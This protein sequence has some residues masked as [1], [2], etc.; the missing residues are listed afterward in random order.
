MKRLLVK[1]GAKGLFFALCFMPLFTW[2]V[3][4]TS[5]FYNS[6]ELPEEYPKVPLADYY[7][8]FTIKNWP[9]NSIDIFEK[10]LADDQERKKNTVIC[11][12]NTSEARAVIYS[13]GFFPGEPVN[14]S[15]KT[16]DGD[17]KESIKFIPNPIFARS[18]RDGAKV[19]AKRID[20]KSSQYMI[21]FSGFPS[22]E[23]LFVESTSYNEKSRFPL[24]LDG[25]LMFVYDPGVINKNGGLASFKVTRASGEILALE[26]PWDLELLRY[27]YIYENGE[28]VSLDKSKE[29]LKTYPQ[30]AKYFKKRKR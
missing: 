20:K 26:I 10:R 29:L 13:L 8:I 22:D 17:T 14:Y 25:P 9:D 27:V 5:D 3:E 30:A 12:S 6:N 7:T 23:K 19:E 21:E 15:F 2:S 28:I 1:F 16:A 18:S 24:K 4:I 11:D